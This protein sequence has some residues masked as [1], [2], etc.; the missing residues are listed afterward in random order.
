MQPTNNSYQDTTQAKLLN[1]SMTILFKQP[2][3]VMKNGTKKGKREVEEELQTPSMI[4]TYICIFNWTIFPKKFVFAYQ[5][6]SPILFSKC[7][8]VS[9]CHQR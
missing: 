3:W 4:I 6:T 9:S 1:S 5:K 7:I 2:D 8:P